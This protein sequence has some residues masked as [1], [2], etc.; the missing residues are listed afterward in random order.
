MQHDIFVSVVIL[1]ALVD[2]WRGAL[3]VVS[4]PKCTPWSEDRG[5]D[6]LMDVVNASGN[7]RRSEPA[8]RGVFL[9]RSSKLLIVSTAF[10]LVKK[11]FNGRQIQICRVV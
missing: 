1:S 6:V 5:S 4:S 3:V 11:M 8:P 7:N 10:S 9:R 2:G